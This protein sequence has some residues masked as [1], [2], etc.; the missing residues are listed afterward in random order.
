MQKEKSTKSSQGILLEDVLLQVHL[1][2]A[3][4]HRCIASRHVTPATTGTAEI[5]EKLAAP[6]AAVSATTG[7]SENRSVSTGSQFV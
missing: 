6:R 1:T 4:L 2:R 5:W 7:N 3:V